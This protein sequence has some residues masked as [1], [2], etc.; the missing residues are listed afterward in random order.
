MNSGETVLLRI[1][2]QIPPNDESVRP[3]QGSRSGYPA[4]PIDPALETELK[5]DLAEGEW[6]M[7][8]CATLH[9]RGQPICWLF[10]LAVQG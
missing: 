2:A 9:G 8:L 5:V 7:D 10:R 6:S 3:F 4:Q 1:E